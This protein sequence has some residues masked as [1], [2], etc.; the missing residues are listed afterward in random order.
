MTNKQKLIAVIVTV[1]LVLVALI[2]VLIIRAVV[3]NRPPKLEEVQGRFEELLESSKEVNRIFWGEGLPT[4]PRIYAEFFNFDA[5]YTYGGVTDTKSLSGY[6]LSDP[7]LGTVVV[8]RYYMTFYP[9]PKNSDE[10][11][12]Y[13]FEKNVI[14]SAVPQGYYRYA[15]RKTEKAGEDYIHHDT[16]KGYYYYALP[17]FDPDSVFTYDE[18][19]EAYYDYVRTDCGYLSVQD[20]KDK[21]ATVYSPAY[22][23]SVSESLFTG[24]TV[25]ESQNGTLYPRYMDYEDIEEGTVTL[26]KLNTEQGYTLTDWVYDYSTMRIVKESN[27][28]FVTVEVERAPADKPEERVTVKQYFTLVDGQWYLDGPSY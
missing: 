9:D 17:D 22:L 19:D 7:T 11:I 27:R 10:T 20:I 6:T 16:E 15:L 18:K 28:S 26:V 1:A 24:I 2:A 5:S 12:T 25:S 3:N 4:Y 8:Y 23:A 14:L 21:A 13:D